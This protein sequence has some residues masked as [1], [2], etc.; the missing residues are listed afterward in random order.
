MLIYNS[1]YYAKQNYNTPYGTIIKEKGKDAHVGAQRYK[2]SDFKGK[3]E[4]CF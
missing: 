3:R 2:T 4:I 1:P